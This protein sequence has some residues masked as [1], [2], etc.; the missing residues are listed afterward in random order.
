MWR[1]ADHGDDPDRSEVLRCQRDVC[2][3]AAEHA[4]D[5]AVRRF[6]AVI[7]DGTYYDQGHV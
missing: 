6:H 5:L 2:G 3:S 1:V 7:R 4:V